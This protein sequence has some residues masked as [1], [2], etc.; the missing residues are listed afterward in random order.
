M[1]ETHGIY[2][3]ATSLERNR[4]TLETQALLKALPDGITSA[5]HFLIPS[6]YDIAA[7]KPSEAPSR[8]TGTITVRRTA[9]FIDLLKDH[10][11]ERTRIF[12][13]ESGT[14]ATFTAIVNFVHPMTDAGDWCDFRIVLALEQDPDFCLWHGRN[15]DPM[16]QLAFAEFL[17]EAE[18]TILNPPAAKL[19][20]LA[21]TL[22]ATQS[23]RYDKGIRLDNGD[24]AFNYRTETSAVGG[25]D[26]TLKIPD[27]I[28]IRTPIWRGGMPMDTD[29]LFR[30]RLREG[31]LLFHFKMIRVADLLRGA[32]DATAENIATETLVPV[33]LGEY[34][35]QF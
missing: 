27:R 23:V 28:T 19:Q 22:K 34:S 7:I 29:V 20:E 10:S 18:L 14:G 35:A 25:A 11:C 26:G 3:I 2:E 17:E 16:D 32:I 4:C 15:N 1:S 5:R 13:R 12:C 33:Y 6:G 8:K 24:I 21:L 31:K 9:D 30:Y